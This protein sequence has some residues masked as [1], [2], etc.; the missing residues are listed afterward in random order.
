MGRTEQLRG[1]LSKLL[2]LR[3]DGGLL[4]RVSNAF[5]LDAALV[6]EVVVDIVRSQGRGTLLLVPEDQVDP[7]VQMS[8]DIVRL[9]G[10]DV[11]ADIIPRATRPGRQHDVVE[12]LSAVAMTQVESFGIDEEVS[13]A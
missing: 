10:L 6:R 8:R 9:E 2:N 13:A 7:L 5:Y 4:T 11:R 3:F 12:T 1:A